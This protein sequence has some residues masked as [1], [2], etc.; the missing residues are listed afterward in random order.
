MPSGKNSRGKRRPK[1]GKWRRNR[2]WRCRG[3]HFL[4][5]CS[6]SVWIGAASVPRA[7][8]ILP[9]C[10]QHPTRIQTMKTT[11]NDEKRRITGE[12][13]IENNCHHR[14]DEESSQK[15]PHC[16]TCHGRR[17]RRRRRTR[18]RGI[19]W[20]FFSDWN[21]EGKARRKKKEK[22]RKEKK[23]KSCLPSKQKNGTHT[24][25]KREKMPVLR[26]SRCSRSKRQCWKRGMGLK[27]KVNP[28][29]WL[30]WDSLLILHW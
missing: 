17:R 3:N 20:F 1:S 21:F 26:R 7:A 4:P 25:R 15:S 8:A 2:H 12:N 19:I 30:G 28:I 9:R 24:Q 23:K 6:I 14:N 11:R 18:K 13:P 29:W 10:Q 22:K 5:T 16:D 27:W